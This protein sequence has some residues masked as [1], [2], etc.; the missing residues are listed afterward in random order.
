M[1]TGHERGDDMPDDSVSTYEVSVEDIHM[2]EKIG[3]GSFGDVFRGELGSGKVIVAV[4]KLKEYD[5]NSV[6]EFER[7]VKVLKVLRHPN[8]VL[9]MGMH[10]SSQDRRLWIITEYLPNGSLKD[11]IKNVNVSWRVKT[12]MAIEIAS[13]LAYLHDR[14]LLHRDLK[15]ENVLLGKNMECKLADFGLSV[16]TRPGREVP[17]AGTFWW[18]APELWAG[19]GYSKEA[20]VFGYGMT[21]AEV[22]MKDAMDDL[23]GEVTVE[24]SKLKFGTDFDKFR[25]MARERAPDCPPV[26]LEVVLGCIADEPEERLALQQVIVKLTTLYEQ[27]QRLEGELSEALEAVGKEAEEAKQTFLSLCLGHFTAAEDAWV[28]TDGLVMRVISASKQ[29]TGVEMDDI[30]VEF[31]LDLLEGNC[32]SAG[33]MDVASYVRF[34][35]EWWYPT[36]V[37]IDSPSILPLYQV[38]FIHGFIGRGETEDKLIEGG[39]DG[40]IIFRFSSSDGGKLVISYLYEQQVFHDLLDVQSRGVVLEDERGAFFG[41]I[42]ELLDD[43]YPE[44]RYIY[45]DHP[46]AS[47]QY[48]S[49]LEQVKA[50]KNTRKRGKS[51]YNRNQKG[52]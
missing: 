35:T 22:I 4:K 47:M 26:W 48:T 24:K 50:A 30:G 29:R 1:E 27:L 28:P 19:S 45:P 49:A 14:N 41:S 9:W 17:T 20:D 3:S 31:M 32:I 16:L 25:Q 52:K 15:T 6:S 10:H 21:L 18:Q 39:K 2:T 44:L 51:T 36:Q 12:R 46:L 33:R 8:I 11:H 37:A 42:A 13:S 40:T 5:A 38:Q 7:E 43:I 34:L 23:R